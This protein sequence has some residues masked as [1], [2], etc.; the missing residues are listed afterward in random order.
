[1]ASKSIL[2]ESD[3]EPELPRVA[4]V[5]LR[6]LQLDNHISELLDMKEEEVDVKVVSVDVEVHLAAHEREAGAKF[7]KGVDDS[8]GE[9]FFQ[10]ALGGV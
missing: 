8:C 5:E 3:I 7:A 10:V 2:D 6:R 1:M 4:R 9:A